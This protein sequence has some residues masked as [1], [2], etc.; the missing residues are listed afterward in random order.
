[1]DSAGN[2]LTGKAVLAG[3]PAA[4]QSTEVSDQGIEELLLARGAD[5]S[6]AA[7]LKYYVANTSAFTLDCVGVIV[8]ADQATADTVFNKLK[9]GAAFAPLARRPRR[10]PRRRR[11]VG[12]SAATSPSPRC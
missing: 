5:L 4:V 8:V 9:A 10:T 1:V 11:P 7:V 12:S 6:D 2:A 3:L